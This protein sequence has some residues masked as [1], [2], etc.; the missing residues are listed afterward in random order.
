KKETEDIW[1]QG[2]Q[3]IEAEG[4]GGGDF[5]GYKDRR[6]VSIPQEQ[7]EAEQRAQDEAAK[8]AAQ[9]SGWDNQTGEVSGAWASDTSTSSKTDTN[10]QKQTKGQSSGDWAEIGVT[11][12]TGGTASTGEW[13]APDWK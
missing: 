10:A 1:D 2:E 9:G 7:I 4:G 13:A 8:Q 3:E 5:G 6:Q 12:Q 11:K